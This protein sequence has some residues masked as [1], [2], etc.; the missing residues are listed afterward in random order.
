MAAEVAE[1]DS[2]ETAQARISGCSIPTTPERDQIAARVAAAI[3]LTSAQVPV[4]ELFWGIRRLFEALA[5]DRPLI[6]LFDDIH[7][8]APTSSSSSSTWSSRQR[9]PIVLVCSA[10]HEL[11][12]ERPDWERRPG[13]QRSS[14]SHS[15]RR[16]RSCSS[17]GCSARQRCPTRSGAGR[18]GRRGQPA[19]CRADGRDAGRRALGERVGHV[20]IRRAAIDPGA[21]RGT[22]RP[23][24]PRGTSDRRAGVGDRAGVPEPAV[25]ELVPDTLKP[26]LGRHLTT[27]R[28]KQFVRPADGGCSRRAARIAS[29]TSSS[30]TPRITRCSSGRE[31][32][33]TSVSW[34]GP[35]RSTANATASRNSRRSSATT[36]SR[37][38]ATGQSW[39][40]ST[41]RPPDRRPRGATPR[42]R[43][44]ACLWPRRPSGSNEPAGPAVALLE[45][46]DP[47]R[48]ELLV[49]LGDAQFDRGMF[50]EALAT[51]TRP[52]G[53]GAHRG[54]AARS[55]GHPE[56][57]DRRDLRGR[58]G[59][60]G[61]ALEATENA[62]P[63]FEEAGDLA[64]LARAWRLRVLVHGTAGRL[65]EA[66]R[67]PSA[68]SSTRRGAG[69]PRMA[70]R[71]AQVYAS[72]AL[73]DAP[74]V[75]SARAL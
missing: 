41:P 51:S 3:G 69:D 27:L 29:T 63:I 33:S 23:A 62:I 25:H 45:T 53:R 74:G 24:Q 4:S 11:L 58:R 73:P 34:R 46:D 67:R 68:S 55:P 40:L 5:A 50:A 57:A 42:W 13:R 36:S 8:A 35:S 49:D 44:A 43:R 48:I 71:G 32:R 21:D 17:T 28:R 64:G 70:A 65:D 18:R 47:Q 31:R 56:Q 54:R 22:S 72:V 61:R 19:L 15:P 14:S 20:R 12:D 2:A 59:A 60:S 10:R 66:R 75:G 39:G 38:S 26:A 9:V 30:G 1:D 6:V 7:D 52:P 16:M 37:R